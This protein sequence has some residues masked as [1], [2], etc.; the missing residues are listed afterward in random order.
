[1]R[2]IIAGSRSF[3]SMPE[4]EE[5][6][7]LSNF[8]ASTVVCGEARGADLLGKQWAIDR[9]IPVHS[10]PANWELQGKGAGFKRNEV[11]A[12]NADAL[13]AFWDGQSSGTKHMIDLA[14][15]KKLEVYIHLIK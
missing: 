8:K 2:V 4:L 11:M 3:H 9:N 10:Y 13:V 6:M 15:R 7:I 1:M 5:A 14:K 12:N